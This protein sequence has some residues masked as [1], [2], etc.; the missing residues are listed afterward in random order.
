MTRLRFLVTCALACAG[1][2]DS[3]QASGPSSPQ[4]FIFTESAGAGD[5]LGAYVETAGATGGTLVLES[6]DGNVCAVGTAL[7]PEPDGGMGSCG[8]TTTYVPAR[9]PQTF[10]AV[11]ELAS[12]KQSGLLTA[13]WFD[14]NGMQLTSTWRRI[15]SVS[16]P[17][18]AGAAVDAA[19]ADAA[20]VVDASAGD[21]Q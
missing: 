6:F 5:A 1:C 9:D 12:G 3:P 16:N 17:P 19:S 4:V 8:T 14:A 15:D 10:A 21:A 2:Q 13:T 7:P 18:D 20:T 11:L